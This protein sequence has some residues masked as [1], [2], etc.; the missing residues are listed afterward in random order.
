[1]NKNLILVSRKQIIIHIFTLVCKKLNISLTVLSEAQL[2]Q[3]VDIVVID[4][5]FIDDRFNI[6]KSYSKLI[7]AISKEELSFETANDFRIP[8][9]FL[10]SSLQVI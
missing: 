3:K 4:S 2:D 7:G 6:L 9:P 8:L 10:P 5:E 1:M